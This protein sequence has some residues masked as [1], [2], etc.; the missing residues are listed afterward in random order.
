MQSISKQKPDNYLPLKQ[1]FK[2]TIWLAGL[3]MGASLLPGNKSCLAQNTKGI[4]L[5]KYAQQHPVVVYA[6]VKNAVI[7]LT[8]SDQLN[9]LLEEGH[10]VLPLSH[11]Q[12][13]DLDGI[14]ELKV[15]FGGNRV[16]LRDVPDLQIFLNNNKLKNL[17][18]EIA[19]LENVSFLYLKSNRFTE[20]PEFIGR[21]KNLKGIYFTHNKISLLPDSLFCLVQLRK[22]E[23]AQNRITRL[24]AAIGNLTELMHFNIADNPLGELPVTVSN[25]KKLRVCDFSRTG[26]SELPQGFAE[27]PVVHQLRL[28]GNPHLK[29]LPVGKGFEQMKGTIEITGTGIDKDDLPPSVQKN[30]SKTKRTPPK[31]DL[32]KRGI[33]VEN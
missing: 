12:L 4:P 20:I 10:N 21:M 31:P 17:P 22:L 33:P 25:L 2:K 14:S 1:V 11:K 24:P 16:M 30:I 26:I 8:P 23:L 19:K 9:N 5:K 32:I 13:S 7:P 29:K 3:M 6:A 28:S 18:E 15:M 27:I